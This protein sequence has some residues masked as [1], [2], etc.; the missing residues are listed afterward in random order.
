MG[1][2]GDVFEAQSRHTAAANPTWNSAQIAEGHITTG[3]LTSGPPCAPQRFGSRPNT[4]FKQKVRGLTGTTANTI[5]TVRSTHRRQD[6][7]HQIGTI[8]E[9]VYLFLRSGKGLVIT[10]QGQ[11][12]KISDSKNCL[13]RDFANEIT[14]H[15]LLRRSHPCT[16]LL[17]TMT[18]G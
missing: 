18:H 11:L 16:D 4:V 5:H 17:G 6:R 15:D 1:L 3:Q 13:V 2:F 9:L 10:D 7:G 8:R 12:G 14:Y